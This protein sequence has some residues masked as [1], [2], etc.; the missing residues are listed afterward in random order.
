MPSDYGRRSKA[1]ARAGEAIVSQLA[2]LGTA[3]GALNASPACSGC[4]G[5]RQYGAVGGGATALEQRGECAVGHLLADLSCVPGVVE[6]GA[7][8][9][10]AL[11]S[12]LRARG[13]G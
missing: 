7:C 2:K 1:G 10:S 12:G 4:A 13:F 11:S 6:H 8:R 9:R 5:Y 3:A